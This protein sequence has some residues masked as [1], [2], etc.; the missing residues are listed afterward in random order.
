MG[1]GAEPKRWAEQ[2]THRKGTCQCFVILGKTRDL[3]TSERGPKT[4]STV[5]FEFSLSCKDHYRARSLKSAECK[6]HLEE[7]ISTVKVHC[8][9]VR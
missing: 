1:E 6:A 4:N 2:K 8:I 3:L 5:A 7:K 9:Q